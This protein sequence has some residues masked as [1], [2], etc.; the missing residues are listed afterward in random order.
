MIVVISNNFSSILFKL[1]QFWMIINLLNP[2]LA[3]YAWTKNRL[4]IEESQVEVVPEFDESALKEIHAIVGQT[5][6]LPCTVRNLGDKVVSWIRKKDLHILTS[7][8]ISFTADNRFEA[9]YSNVDFWGLR[10][11]G[12]KLSDM[13]QYECQVNTDPKI[14]F[15]MNLSVSGMRDAVDINTKYAYVASIKG[16]K[17]VYVR[18]GS[19]VTFTCEIVSQTGA[20]DM[21]FPK[22]RVKWLYESK[23]ITHE[24]DR[25][26][27]SVDTDYR[28]RKVTSRLRVAVVTT[29]DGGLYACTQA[30]TL[31]DSVRLIVVEAEHSEA[32]QRDFP[33]AAGNTA[34]TP[35]GTV[36]ISILL[37]FLVLFNI[38]LLSEDK[39]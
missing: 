9:L 25:G 1:I 18:V 23:E 36:V 38:L 15:A 8:P 5:I 28:D 27:I 10:I 31:G 22:P 3:G 35:S 6:V 34:S 19:P 29:K 20:H 32:M 30:A 14:N 7:G 26:G 12:V 33:V 13:G 24:L 2:L 39:S 21:F 37:C 16:P 4:N 17:E 11:R